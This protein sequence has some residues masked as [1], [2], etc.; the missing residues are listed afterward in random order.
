MICYLQLIVVSSGDD[1]SSSSTE[2][3]SYSLISVAAAMY[4]M[5]SITAAD[6]GAGIAL[7][8]ES[9]MNMAAKRWVQRKMFGFMMLVSF[10]LLA[11]AS[12][13]VLFK[14]S[15][16]DVDLVVGA[17]TVLFIADVVSKNVWEH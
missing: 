6:L 9:R 11:A 2:N 7:I 1:S 5:T 16:E 13:M 15:S 3:G 14:T 10:V 4:L 17:A 8:S 12:I